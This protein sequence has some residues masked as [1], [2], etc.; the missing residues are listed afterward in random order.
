MKRAISWIEFLITFG[1]FVAV[2]I[3]I[4]KGFITFV[5]TLSRQFEEFTYLQESIA[6]AS[7]ILSYPNVSSVDYT[8][9]KAFIGRVYRNLVFKYREVP[10][11]IFLKKQY[12][13]PTCTECIM[14]YY[15]TTN[16]CYEL[17]VKS[18]RNESSILSVILY[19]QGNPVINSIN[20]A[21][22]VC[23]D[24]LNVSIV[25]LGSVRSFK[26]CDII[27][28]K[29]SGVCLCNVNDLLIVDRYQSNLDFYLGRD[30]IF[31]SQGPSFVLSK[32][33]L[34]FFK[35]ENDTIGETTLSIT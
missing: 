4:F 2:V 12:S 5:H 16:S 24:F 27:M 28:Y 23:Y 8:T 20:N 26:Y 11:V 3:W 35:Y 25:K 14:F 1:V 19:S 31:K 34:N 7:Y 6:V 10:Y 15:N 33:T 17:Y 22:I 30:Y 29:D 13:K 9:A 32:R 21:Q 18:P